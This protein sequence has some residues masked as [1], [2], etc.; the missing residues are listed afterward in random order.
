MTSPKVPATRTPLLLVDALAVHVECNLNSRIYPNSVFNGPEISRLAALDRFV[1]LAL[2]ASLD[3]FIFVQTRRI[4]IG[5]V[6]PTGSMRRVSQPVYVKSATP[7]FSDPAARELAG[8]F[9][10]L[11][12]WAMMRDVGDLAMSQLESRLLYSPHIR[13]L[14]DVFLSHP[15]ARGG[16]SIDSQ[17]DCTGR[18]LAELCNDFVAHF[19]QTMREKKL[20][21]RER[22]NWEFGS[23]E[24]VA[25]LNTYLDGLFAQ[26]GSVTVLHLR[27]SH[28]RERASLISAP[29]E[30]QHR[31]LQALRRSRGIFLDRIR[32]KPSLF[33]DAPGSVWS[34][35]PS[36][37][38]GYELHITLLFNSVALRRVLE[39]RGMASAELADAFTD[40][41]DQVG[42]YWV[43]IATEGRGSYLR[44]DQSPWLY[45]RNW[46]H[47]EVRADDISR[48][49]KLKEMLG[50]LALRRALVRLKNEPPG[51]YFRVSERQLRSPR[52]SVRGAETRRRSA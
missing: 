3:P 32:R 35:I 23:R 6:G 51:E 2:E 28:A 11:F 46:V 21:R 39:D 45:N 38:G 42:A 50:Y 52:R 34:I 29:V 16:C 14:L 4:F 44:G 47:G 7:N 26:N 22:H 8:L 33:T 31:D 13:L 19:R 48:C 12:F 30:E 49:E 37:E 40:Y 20:L 9:P 43:R 24:N 15:V 5:Q 41:A 36:F 27:L 17:V 1:R 10:D 25:N 18:I